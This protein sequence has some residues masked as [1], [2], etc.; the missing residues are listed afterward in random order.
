LDGVFAIGNQDTIYQE[1]E[2]LTISFAR[3]DYMGGC[4]MIPGEGNT[5]R[6]IYPD[7]GSGFQGR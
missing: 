3:D 5:K 1:V 4:D 6:M 2:P 7:I